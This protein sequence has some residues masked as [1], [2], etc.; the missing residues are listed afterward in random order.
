MLPELLRPAA[1][2]AWP[3]GHARSSPPAMW[4]RP[5]ALRPRG[6]D[7][8][9]RRCCPHQAIEGGQRVTRPRPGPPQDQ[10]GL[11]ERRPGCD[12]APALPGTRP[13]PPPSPPPDMRRSRRAAGAWRACHDRPSAPP[14][15]ARSWRTRRTRGAAARRL[16]Q[17]PEP[18][19]RHHR[20]PWP[21]P[22]GTRPAGA[23]R[24]PR[25]GPGTPR[26][27]PTAVSGPTTTG[28]ISGCR[29]WIWPSTVRTNPRR[30]AGA[31]DASDSR[32]VPSAAST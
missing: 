11:G 7:R 13:P 9:D 10:L 31:R 26:L 23:P 20:D 12:T 29:S 32:S 27:W 18:R 25:P 2:P 1:R 16:P 3:G 6:V 14:P 24:R 21:P 19:L 15:A 28:R 8:P 5:A 4:P 22:P 30:S 17:P